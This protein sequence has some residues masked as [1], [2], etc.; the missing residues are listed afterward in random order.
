MMDRTTVSTTLPTAADLRVNDRDP[1]EVWEAFVAYVAR[2]LAKPTYEAE[3][4]EHRLEIAQRMGGF[5]ASMRD[6]TALLPASLETLFPGTYGGLAYDFTPD[7]HWIIRWCRQDT[8]SFT[9]AMNL[10]LD[11]KCSFEDRFAWFARCA[12]E[13][14]EAQIVPPNDAAVMSY[15][16]LFNFAAEPDNAPAIRP[17]SFDLLEQLLGFGSV[18]ESSLSEQYSNHIAFFRW[19]KQRLVEEDVEVRDGVDVQSLIWLAAQEYEFW[20]TPP[21][22][23]EVELLRARN[24]ARARGHQPAYLSIGAIYRNEGPYMREW[25]EFHRLV[26][27]ERFF[28]YDN[29]STDEHLEVLQPYIEDGSVT[30]HDWPV[31]PTQQMERYDMSKMVNVAGHLCPQ[32]KAYDHCLNEHGAESRWI[33]FID[34]DEFLFAPG[35]R[36]LPETL[37]DYEEWPGVG[38]SAALFGPCSNL[39]MPDGLVVE[40]YT[41]SIKGE[42]S[43]IKSIV[44]PIRAIRCSTVHH[45]IY[46]HRSAVDENEYPIWGEVAKGA[47]YSRLRI[48]H[49]WS[50]SEEECRA[51]FATPRAD[52]GYF[53]AWPS[54]RT[55]RERDEKIAEPDDS[56]SGYVD[57]LKELT[58][59]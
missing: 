52:N 4:R 59:D 11:E 31:F 8:D 5:L 54:F 42:T 20:F 27:V 19:L 13:A 43:L 23:E 6:G 56:L 17:W 30:L 58:D 28:L 47:S 3:E 53:R 12:Q 1:S 50:K 29:G 22:A 44:D 2:A 49:Y 26:G 24:S 36:S 55:L 32:M 51:K 14:Q 10:F 21:P 7:V 15:G 38:V 48:N 9:K 46:R 40:N 45:F 25:I 18:E 57:R 37:V 33:A 39:T 34:L 35:D 16:S 41:R